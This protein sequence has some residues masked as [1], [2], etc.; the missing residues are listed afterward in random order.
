MLLPVWFGQPIEILF[1]KER[2][3]PPSELEVHG[4]L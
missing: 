1:E 2:V 4:S 3:D